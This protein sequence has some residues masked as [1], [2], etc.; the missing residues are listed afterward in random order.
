[1]QQ[2]YSIIVTNGCRWTGFSLDSFF[3]CVSWVPCSAASQVWS[4]PL[5]T[6]SRKCKFSTT[7]QFFCQR[8]L[9]YWRH[10][11]MIRTVLFRFRFLISKPVLRALSGSLSSIVWLL[12]LLNMVRVCLCS[13]TCRMCVKAQPLWLCYDRKCSVLLFPFFIPLP[14]LSS[15][16]FVGGL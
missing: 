5:A 14:V 4:C 1:M 10:L 9:W 11:L 13:G 16:M 6:G 2:P 12:E 3:R 7:A 8:L 15:I